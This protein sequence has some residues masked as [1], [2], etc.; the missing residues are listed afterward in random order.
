MAC[1][2]LCRQAR[3]GADAATFH[4]RAVSLKHK[5]YRRGVSLA[6]VEAA[7]RMDAM[8]SFMLG[9]T[10]MSLPRAGGTV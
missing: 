2:S 6:F 9:A 3:D 1:C 5:E 8:N 7:E 10:V 4:C